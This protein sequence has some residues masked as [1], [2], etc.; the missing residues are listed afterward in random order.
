MQWEKLTSNDFRSAVE[1]T[2]V[3]VIAMGVVERH[4]DHLPSALISQRSRIACLAAERKNRGGLSTFYFGQIYE[5]RCFPGT[6]T[7]KPNLL[8][9]VLWNVFDEI[10]GMV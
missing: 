7:L 1:A 4:S 8:L 9:D 6:I 3:C 10:A 2:Q 5:A